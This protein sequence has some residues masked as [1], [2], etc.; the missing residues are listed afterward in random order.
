[1]HKIMIFFKTQEM[2]KYRIAMVSD[3]F[4]PNKGGV[5][6]HII[7]VS[8]RLISLGHGVIA[9]THAYP[10]CPTI[11]IYKNIKIY[12]LPTLLINNTT[13]PSIFSKF[14]SVVT[15]LKE[16][17][18]DIVHG[19]QSMSALAV[20]TILHAQ[21]L[22]LKTVFTEHSL[23][24]SGAFENIVVNKLNSIVLSNVDK[25]ICV[26]YTLKEN[27]IKRIGVDR[28]D[29]HVIPNGVSKRF[30]KSKIKLRKKNKICENLP[31]TEEI[32]NIGSSK[33]TNLLKIEENNSSLYKN[34]EFEKIS[35]RREK[36]RI[37]SCCRFVY[38]KGID[39]LIRTIPKICNLDKRIEFLIIGDGVKKFELERMIDENN[40][41]KRVKLKDGV[42]H[43]KMPGVF[44]KHD[45][46][47]NTSLTESFCI[48]IIEA[49]ACGLQVVSTN[50]GAVSE[51][52]PKNM[53]TL[54]NLTDDSI[55]EGVAKAIKKM[56]KKSKKV[57]FYKSYDWKLIAKETVG[58]YDNIKDVRSGEERL[59]RGFFNFLP[60]MIVVFEYFLLFLYEK[61]N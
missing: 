49:A 52:L 54:V 26:S 39:I 8:T 57:N 50:V 15:I 41:N 42:E 27:F 13:F 5:E 9:I 36:I 22:G 60:R 59:Q 12:Y 6:T 46:F 21:T 53:I 51:V 45:I 32:S 61:F 37:I 16:E 48:A 4:Y 29:V 43:K 30:I 2:S 7:S 1:M 31:K 25:V 20:E 3:F 33:D 28:G 10:G 11:S 17:K 19:H 24:E 40:L 18:I 34:N 35:G 47:L 55:L 38:R 56:K 58:V 44:S 23:F 14:F